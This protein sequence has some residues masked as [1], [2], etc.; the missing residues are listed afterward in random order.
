M[1][2]T[3]MMWTNNKEDVGGERKWRVTDQM[4]G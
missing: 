4:K 2:N 1:H 3:L